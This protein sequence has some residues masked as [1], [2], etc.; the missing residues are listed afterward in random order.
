MVHDVQLLKWQKISEC[1]FSVKELQCIL[2]LI[3][4]KYGIFCCDCFNII[5]IFEQ[6]NIYILFYHLDGHKEKKVR[7]KIT[8]ILSGFEIY[9][10]V[11]LPLGQPRDLV[12][13]PTE[14]FGCPSSCPSSSQETNTGSLTVAFIN[15]NKKMN[16]KYSELH[17]RVS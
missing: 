12:W 16:Y 4:D 1:A 5:L 10:Y 9:F 14:Y 13:L 17:S 8:Y 7:I 2:I 6:K 11:Q 3:L 15:L